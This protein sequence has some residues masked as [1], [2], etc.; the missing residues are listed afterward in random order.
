MSTALIRRPDWSSPDLGPGF[1]WKSTE[2][3]G[4]EALGPD[5]SGIRYELNP[6]MDHQG[7]YTGTFNLVYFSPDSRKP[8]E[9]GR[10]HS[11]ELGRGVLWGVSRMRALD[12]LAQL[13]QETPVDRMALP[14]RTRGKLTSGPR[15]A[16]PLPSPREAQDAAS[17]V[18]RHGYFVSEYVRGGDLSGATAIELRALIRAAK[19]LS[20]GHVERC[21]CSNPVERCG[22]GSYLPELA[23][24]AA[25]EML[26]AGPRKP[27]ITRPGKLGGK[28]FLARPQSERRRI[29]DNCVRRY[30]YRSCLGSLQ[31]LEH[32]RAIA[33]AHSAEI[34]SDTAYL[35]EKY[36]GPGS[37]SPRHM[38]STTER[39]GVKWRP[40]EDGS[41]LTWGHDGSDL[42]A[43]EHVGSGQYSTIGPGGTSLGSRDSLGKAKALASRSA[44]RRASPP[45]YTLEEARAEGVVVSGIPGRT[46]WPFGVR[47]GVRGSY[48]VS[49][50]QDGK[51][52]TYTVMVIDPN[53][54]TTHSFRGSTHAK[55]PGD[56][57]IYTKAVVYL[58]K[59]ARG[60]RPSV[61]RMP[62]KPTPG[63]K[64]TLDD[65]AADGILVNADA[66]LPAEIGAHQRGVKTSR[67]Y[68]SAVRAFGRQGEVRGTCV[69]YRQGAGKGV[70]LSAVYEALGED[71]ADPY[72][73]EVRPK[74]D[75][76]RTVIAA[77]R[78][79]IQGSRFPSP[80]PGGPAASSRRSSPSG[81]YT[82][83]LAKKER[84][85]VESKGFR[86]GLFGWSGATPIGYKDEFRGTFSALRS[87][88]AASRAQVETV[89]AVIDDEG[90]RHRTQ[91]YLSGNPTPARIAAAI[92]KEVYAKMG[93]DAEDAVE[94][95]R[96]APM[97]NDPDP[98]ASS[99][100]GSQYTLAQA[101]HEGTLV[102]PEAFLRF[103]WDEWSAAHRARVEA[104][105]GPW[106]GDWSAPV[107]FG[108]VGGLRGTY[109]IEKNPRGTS[110]YVKIA[111][112]AVDGLG[113][114]YR[115]IAGKSGTR[116][117]PLQVIQAEIR[118][119]NPVERMPKIDRPARDGAAIGWN[120]TQGKRTRGHADSLG[121]YDIE[122][123][124][125]RGATYFTVYGPGGVEVASKGTL[126]L[127]KKAAEQDARLRLRGMSEGSVERM[128]EGSVVFGEGSVVQEEAFPPRRYTWADGLLP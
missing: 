91:T 52:V 99:H 51:G 54:G 21:G 22:H 25:I 11:E 38:R 115:D 125:V 42:Y 87:K 119:Q 116:V 126:G 79:D 49:E 3:G 59:K 15:R 76:L 69:V 102:T 1:T 124:V 84:T 74:S 29:L 120:A 57:D 48:V 95:M 27:W 88:D 18:E 16:E 96:G 105:G 127:A 118:N 100:E 92:R 78:K 56:D 94:R 67:V 86:G 14:V 9:G 4:G 101:K 20:G 73:G 33:E 80:E 82:L 10:R 63:A 39:M 28:G 107:A 40:Q 93:E 83:A 123:S 85:L 111:Y 7:R 62:V 46:I 66:H 50:W 72:H 112:L 98:F 37:F 45:V 8:S 64:Y 19:R 89:Y 110:D 41:H 122:K 55:V 35:K 65:A 103:G 13:T 32:N 117:N 6:R 36:G 70:R 60:V 75:D 24:E 44:R 128:A 5:F 34:D 109:M 90:G 81:R 104:R 61:E 23:A 121:W 106:P 31:V 12:K 58:K 2:G 53:D 77:I 71:G 30:G 26:P 113:R 108:R 97:D 47:G 17:I 68:A 114:R 43:V